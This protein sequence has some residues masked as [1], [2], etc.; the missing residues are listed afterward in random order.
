MSVYVMNDYWILDV[1]DIVYLEHVSE[2][3]YNITHHVG[4]EVIFISYLCHIVSV[5]VFYLKSKNCLEV[6]S[7]STDY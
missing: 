1:S 7:P 6:R 2:N 5:V 4:V 3:S